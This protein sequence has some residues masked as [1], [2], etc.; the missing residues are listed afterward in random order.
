MI[1]LLI[2]II[3]DT[4]ELVDKVTLFGEFENNKKVDDKPRWFKDEE[5]YLKSKCF[6]R[7]Y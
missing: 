5:K 6:T 4:M 3:S 1:L 2:I 7:T